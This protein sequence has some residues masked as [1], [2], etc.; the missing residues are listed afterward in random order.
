MSRARININVI[1]S[2]FFLISALLHNVIL[3]QAELRR[4]DNL[5]F[6]FF[7]FNCFL[8]CQVICINYLNLLVFSYLS[9]L[10]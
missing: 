9:T 8:H 10:V 5:T 2:S 7:T 3:H 6:S 4:L 1:I